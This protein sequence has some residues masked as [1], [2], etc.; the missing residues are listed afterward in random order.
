MDA[1]LIGLLI[2]KT[3]LAAI[4]AGF[5]HEGKPIHSRVSTFI[6]AKE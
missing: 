5:I 6:Q 2:G 4:L 1:N 3:I